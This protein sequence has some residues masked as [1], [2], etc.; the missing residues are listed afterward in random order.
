MSTNQSN[1][2]VRQPDSPN[3]LNIL[4]LLFFLMGAPHLYSVVRR[5]NTTPRLGHLS[6]YGRLVLLAGAIATILELSLM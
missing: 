5:W 3:K 2:Y 4:G 1:L 6:R